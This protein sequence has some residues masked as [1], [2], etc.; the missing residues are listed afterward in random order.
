MKKLWLSLG[1]AFVGTAC[2]AAGVACNKEDNTPKTFVVTF[3]QE[4]YAPISKP[5]QEGGSLVDE[6]IPELQA[7]TGYTVAW[8][9][10]EGELTN[11]QSNIT[12]NAVFTA[13]EYTVTFD[14]QEGETL[15]NDG[16]GDILT[17]QVTYDSAYSLPTPAK[18][19]YIFQYWINGENILATTGQKWLI[20]ENISVTAVWEEDNSIV[21]VT[22][23]YL[24]NTTT[25]IQVENG[26]GLEQNQI[27]VL[28]TETGYNIFWDKDN[29]SNITEDCT[30]FMQKT[31]KTYNLSFNA[32]D[33]NLPSNAPT[34]LQVV[35]NEPY[36]L[37]VPTLENY[38]FLGWYAN[39][40]KV[41][42]YGTNWIYD[43]A[44]TVTLTAKWGYTVRFVQ[45]GQTE[46]VKNLIK[47]EYLTE[48]DIPTPVPVK[49]HTVLW[50]KDWKTINCN[51]TITAVATAN[52]YT[53]TF[54]AGDKCTFT[55]NKETVKSFSITIKYGE[56]ID[57]T[58]IEKI[59]NHNY[60]DDEYSFWGWKDELGR[61]VLNG[62]IYDWDTNVIIQVDI[63]SDWIGPY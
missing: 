20:A 28:P 53:L 51:A 12:I 55:W 62:R 27:P 49:G 5:V 50:N 61:R 33:G 17:Q 59:I 15:K 4:G 32:T 60:N 35:Y 37:V 47:G 6:N 38:V 52:E 10:D 18:E 3:V 31:P 25:T 8:D 11:I 42:T 48:A 23:V 39:E 2:L 7:R 41:E 22:F 45:D 63:V 13:N 56:K 24:D 34:S 54:D 58:S 14:L 26:S 1:L 9:I 57:L 40:T 19:D 43:L 46:I 21:D 16:G 44:E 36:S 29:F 30:V